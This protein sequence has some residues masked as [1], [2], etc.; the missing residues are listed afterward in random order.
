MA[1]A[2]KATAK[3]ESEARF[4]F[5]KNWRNFLKL[6]S[7]DRIVAAEESLKNMLRLDSLRGR[8]FLDIGSGSGLFSLAAYRLG[9]EVVSFDYDRESVAATL[10]LR[11]RFATGERDW[12]VEEGSVLDKA[13]LAGLGLFDVVYSWGVL[14]HTGSQWEA[15]AN[16]A[17]AVKPSGGLYVALYNDQGVLSRFWALVKKTYN[18]G[19]AGRILTSAVFV[20]PLTLFQA[21]RSLVLTGSPFR[22]YTRHKERGMSPLHDVFDWIGGWP[23]EVSSPGEVLEFL[24]RRDFTLE[25]LVTTNGHG[26]NEFLFRRGGESSPREAA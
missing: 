6:L 15:L 12:R 24:R 13:Y 10:S 9:A 11:S 23:F 21:G 17:A 1:P 3:A 20:P 14:H 5:G 2:S 22:H 26:N 19:P 4:G 8:R 16:A 25:K 18:S 7:E